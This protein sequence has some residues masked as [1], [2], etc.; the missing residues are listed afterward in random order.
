MDGLRGFWV[1]SGVEVVRV[2]N[3]LKGLLCCCGCCAGCAVEGLGD[4]AAHGLVTGL[5]GCGICCTCA[6]GMAC[7]ES[8]GGAVRVA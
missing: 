3:A 6:A 2:R 7:L 4:G 5:A 1:P 8:S